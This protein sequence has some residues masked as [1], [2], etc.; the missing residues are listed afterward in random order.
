M[1]IQKEKFSLVKKMVSVTEY[2]EMFKNNELPLI[3]KVEES[4]IDYFA[5]Y[6]NDTK[7]II[8]DFKTKKTL[9]SIR[10]KEKKLWILKNISII[11]ILSSKYKRTVDTK[12]NEQE[13]NVEI[14]KSIP[15]WVEI[16]KYIDNEDIKEVSGVNLE[17]SVPSITLLNKSENIEMIYF[18]EVSIKELEEEFMEEKQKKYS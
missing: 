11:G 2:I 15:F 1:S 6:I 18:I 3:V 17:G 8:D 4:D 14:L 12:L 9:D 7:Y 16:D 13:A 10:R 5:E